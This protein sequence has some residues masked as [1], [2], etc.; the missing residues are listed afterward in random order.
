MEFLL[1]TH[2]SVIVLPIK[3]MGGYDIIPHV[4]KKRNNRKQ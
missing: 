3:L 4:P 1:I 2:K